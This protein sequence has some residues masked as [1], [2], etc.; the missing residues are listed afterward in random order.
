MTHL[1]NMNNI[2]IRKGK[3]T[4]RYGNKYCEC[5]G[6]KFQSIREMTH[7]LYLRD[8]KLKGEIKDFKMQVPYKCIINDVLICSYRADFVVTHWDYTEEVIDVKGFKTA[9]YKLKYKLMQACHN[10]KIKEIV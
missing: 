10:I 8:R 7:Y 9:V 4:S 3:S 1:I 6:F 5:D 2:S